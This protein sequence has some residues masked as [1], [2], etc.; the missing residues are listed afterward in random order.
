MDLVDLVQIPLLCLVQIQIS[1]VEQSTS[2]SGESIVPGKS[3]DFGDTDDNSDTGEFGVTCD[4]GDTG[5][6]GNTG[7]KGSLGIS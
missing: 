2:G 6:F 1:L 3:G 7:Y 4:N 5:D